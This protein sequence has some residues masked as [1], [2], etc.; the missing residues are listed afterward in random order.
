[1]NLEKEFEEKLFKFLD[2]SEDIFLELKEDIQSSDEES[3]NDF[4][5]FVDDWT[6]KRFKQ[7][8][9]IR[10]ISDYIVASASG[11]DLVCNNEVIRHFSIGV[12]ESI[13]SGNASRENITRMCNS[14]DDSDDFEAK[15]L[16]RLALI[17]EL[18]Y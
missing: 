1:M 15:T 11:L 14:I 10:N 3:Q 9:T 7:D 18:T 8:I 12:I 5:K 6:K 16:F 13:G 17:M 4:D 2:K